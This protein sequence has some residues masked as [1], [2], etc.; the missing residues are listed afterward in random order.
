MPQIR[1]TFPA[2]ATYA[3]SSLLLRAVLFSSCYRRS[4]ATTLI[5]SPSPCNFAA[6]PATRSCEPELVTHDHG[7]HARVACVECHV[8]PGA[9][10]FVKSKISGCL[11]A[12][13]GR[14]RQIPASDSD[15]NQKP[16][17]RARD[18]RAMPLAAVVRRQPRPHLHLFSGRRFQFA[19][20]NPVAHQNRWRGSHARATGGIHWHILKGNKVE[21]IATDKARQNIPWVRMTDA[22]GVV[23]VFKT[24]NFTN[25][26]SKMEIRTMDC[27]DCHNRPAHRYLSPNAAVN[28][29]LAQGKIDPTLLWI[30]DQ[31]RLCPHAQL[32]DGRGCAATA[33]PPRWPSIIPTTLAS[34]TRFLWFSA[35][36]R[37]IS[38][39]K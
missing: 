33:S 35:F 2:R 39:R 20:L 24:R 10:W 31:R 23:T 5:T 27:M 16:A 19:L 28:G 3:S 36:T 22:Q 1:I 30:Q 25:D 4:A 6:R 26:I 38:S 14:L 21:Y 34:V 13:C 15:A 7:P 12:L 11:P 29:A 37:T 9:S 17:P 18:V 8:G 32:Q